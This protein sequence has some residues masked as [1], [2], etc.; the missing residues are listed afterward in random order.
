M[1]DFSNIAMIAGGVIV[2]IILV[3]LIASRIRI[4]A[5]NQ[6][7]IIAGSGTN[8]AAND[9]DGKIAAASDL[10]IVTGGRVIVPPFT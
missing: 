3:M 2:L 9:N 5:P 8:A 1:P 6:A 4:P 7:F 10:K